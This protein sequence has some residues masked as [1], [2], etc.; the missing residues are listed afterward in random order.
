MSGGCDE[1]FVKEKKRKREKETSLSVTVYRGG[2]RSGS[3]SGKDKWLGM[4]RNRSRAEGDTVAYE[5][6]IDSA[7]NDRL[8]DWWAAASEPARF[9]SS[10]RFM[11]GESTMRVNRKSRCPLFPRL[12][13]YEREEEEEEEEEERH[14]LS[15][16]FLLAHDPL[17]WIGRGK[18]NELN[19][20]FWQSSTPTGRA[21]LFFSRNLH[22]VFW[23]NLVFEKSILRI[24]LY[25]LLLRILEEERNYLGRL[26]LILEILHFFQI[27]NQNWTNN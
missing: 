9:V 14:R 10:E 6:L 15:R 20:D 22:S 26:F 1:I 13:S 8:S 25:S 24:S 18:G 12:L 2:G 21:T 16:S 17:Y 11:S 4:D 7:R 3:V 23:L 5:V 27:S 19:P